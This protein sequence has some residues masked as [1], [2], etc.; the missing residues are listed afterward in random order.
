[1]MNRTLVSWRSAAV[2]AALVMTVSTASQAQK[3]V[4]GGP[5]EWLTQYMSARTLG[6][7]GAFVARADEPLGVLW[8]PAGLSFM[9][10]NEL[11][12]ET[13]RMF[14]GA[15]INGGAFAVPGSRF[16]SLGVSMV[17]LSSGGFEKT[18]ELNDPL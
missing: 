11:R 3:E 6:L 9:D 14:E 16:P 5:G 8:N 1:M 12:L 7:G 2:A 15:T 13:A 17:S 18:D 10:Q 4:A